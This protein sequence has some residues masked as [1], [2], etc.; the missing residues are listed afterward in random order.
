MHS[1]AI[2]GAG[3]DALTV[4]SSLRRLCGQTMDTEKIPLSRAVLQ[5]DL[6]TVHITIWGEIA[7]KRP[8]WP[9]IL[10][11]NKENDSLCTHMPRLTH[12]PLTSHTDVAHEHLL[13]SHTH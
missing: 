4:A 9:C 11:H 8:V 5:V 6:F 13:E 3:G 1:F 10:A 7:L 12:T 2:L